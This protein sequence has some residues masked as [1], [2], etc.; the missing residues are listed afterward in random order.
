MIEGRANPAKKMTVDLFSA[1][2]INRLLQ[3]TNNKGSLRSV[4][5]LNADLERILLW[6]HAQMHQGLC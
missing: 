1:E 6:T 5:V 2:A 4:A 3:G